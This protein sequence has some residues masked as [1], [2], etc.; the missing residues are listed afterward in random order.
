[1][2]QRITTEIVKMVKFCITPKVSKTNFMQV[3][4]TTRISGQKYQK[5]M[6]PEILKTIRTLR[7]LL[8]N[9]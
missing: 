2:V 1:M 3:K 4:S 9:F 7:S 5:M 6:V 8:G